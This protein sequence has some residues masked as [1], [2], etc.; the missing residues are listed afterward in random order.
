MIID[1]ASFN[2]QKIDNIFSFKTN[3]HLCTNQFDMIDLQSSSEPAITFID[4]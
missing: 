1:A 4:H 2:Y 3:I